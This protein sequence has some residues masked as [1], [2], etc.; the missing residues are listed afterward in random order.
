MIFII[1][2]SIATQ[3]QDT[4]PSLGDG[5]KFYGQDSSFYTRFGFRFQNLLTNQW[6][7]DDGDFEHMELN[8]LVR[9]AR[10][11]FD[12]YAVSP[13]LKYK[14]ELALTNRDIGSELDDPLN[15]APKIILDAFIDWNF[16][17]NWSLKVGQAKLPGNR[18][19]VISSGDMQFVER[20]SLNRQYNI[21]RDVGM[22]V[23]HHMTLRNGFYIKKIISVTQGEGRN[24][25][26]GNDG[27][28]DYTFR[29][30]LLPFGKFDNKGDYT[31][32]D[33]ERTKSPKLSLGFTY[34]LNKRNVRTRGQNGS[35]IR[36]EAG[37]LK[38]RTL[39][40]FFA[41]MMFKYDGFSFMGEYVH[42]SAAGDDPFIFSDAGALIGTLYTGTGLNLNMGYLLEKNWEVALRYTYIHL[43]ECVSNRETE[44]TFGLS[45]YIVGH[46][47]KVQ[48]DLGYINIQGRN[49][50]FVNRLQ[51]DIHF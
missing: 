14:L 31:S 20:S 24:V 48:T 23:S 45:K 30:E 25:T 38:G 42:K 12:G 17:K 32:S 50:M 2:T 26:T 18:E 46:N 35:F 5:F 1:T 36:D 16:Y 27:G 21:D 29:A 34:D 41:D 13:R 33:L 6:S 7:I 19:R 37:T 10:L 11:K 22:Q 49:N 9:R 40:T 51:M 8:F 28:L 44:Y 47:L 43:D 15:N 3:A 39:M 4:F